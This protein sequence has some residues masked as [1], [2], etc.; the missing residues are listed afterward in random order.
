MSSQTWSEPASGLKWHDEAFSALVPKD[1]SDA[2]LR[3]LDPQGGSWFRS[4]LDDSY[5]LAY[6]FQ[7]APGGAQPLS[8]FNLRRWLQS[9]PLG[10]R[11]RAQHW[12]KRLELAALDGS[13]IRMHGVYR[14][15]SPEEASYFI[16]LFFEQLD[17]SGASVPVFWE[18]L[19]DRAIRQLTQHFI[20]HWHI[21][22]L[23][24]ILRLD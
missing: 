5:D 4:P 12:G 1:F 10:R 11:I 20:A 2:N 7:G 6:R 21:R 15:E 18:G 8:L 3:P 16:L 13:R 14:T 22:S 23:E 24:G 17:W 19:D 9:E